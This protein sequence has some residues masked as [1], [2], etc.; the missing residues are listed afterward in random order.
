MKEHQVSDTDDTNADLWEAH[1]DWW[2]REFTDGVDP[3]YTEQLLPIV[4]EWTTGFEH[5]LEVGA[6]EGQVARAMAEKA[7]MPPV[8]AG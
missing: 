7:L 2:Q 5:I 1:A 3:E 6:G 4:V 8:V